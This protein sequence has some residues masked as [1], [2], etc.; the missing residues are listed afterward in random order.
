MPQ[1][2]APSSGEARRVLPVWGQTRREVAE[3][4]VNKRLLQVLVALAATLS[5]VQPAWAFVED[6]PPT[7][8]NGG[9][10]PQKTGDP[11][12][13]AAAQRAL[14][15]FFTYTNRVYSARGFANPWLMREE[16][17]NRRTNWLNKTVP[18]ACGRLVSG[19]KNM[20]W[21]PG[22]GWQ[23]EVP[24]RAIR[25]G[26]NVPC[27]FT[28]PT[29]ANG[30]IDPRRTADP[31]AVAAA[32]QA[33]DEFYRETNLSYSQNGYTSAWMM[34]EALGN[35]QSAWLDMTLPLARAQLVG[36]WQ[37]LN[38]VVGRGWRPEAPPPVGVASGALIQGAAGGPE[39]LAW[40]ADRKAAA[41]LPPVL[42][43]AP[44][45]PPTPV[46][47]PEALRIIQ[48]LGLEL[49]GESR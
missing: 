6:T 39:I 45:R 21:V 31:A 1:R 43:E 36:G 14:E 40:T 42:A 4:N 26:A 47:D 32:Q 18:L 20:N 8:A 23:H 13:V 24:S 46:E 2:R 35:E 34:R 33:L 12:A 9:V 7:F 30:G 25:R 28:A 3:K 17:G 5:A 37:N 48:S 11:P 41:P 19:W 38:W 22:R 44:R 49:G 29:F 27:E 10:D 15:E 16:V